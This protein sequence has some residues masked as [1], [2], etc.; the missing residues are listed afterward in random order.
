[1]KGKYGLTP[2]SSLN[3]LISVVGKMGGWVPFMEWFNGG[4]KEIK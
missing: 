3:D 1:L 4:G 2:Q